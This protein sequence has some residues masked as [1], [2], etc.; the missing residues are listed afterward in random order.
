M[1][2]ETPNVPQSQYELSASLMRIEGK[3]DLMLWR[4]DQQALKQADL[5]KEVNDTK[6]RVV[7]VEHKVNRY[8]AWVAGA[9]A[10]VGAVW[11]LFQEG[12][13]EAVGNLW[14]G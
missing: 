8:A 4:I 1:T 13:R 11:M 3:Q 5:E 7:R 10:A 14:N 9:V 6:E 2:D 12:I